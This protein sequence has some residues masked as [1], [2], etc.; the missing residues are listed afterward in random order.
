MLDPCAKG[1]T[2]GRRDQSEYP[3]SDTGNASRSGQMTDCG[4]WY[5]PEEGDYLRS[6]WDSPA[7]PTESTSSSNMY[8]SDPTSDEANKE[9][10]AC[11]GRRDS[12]D[13]PPI[14]WAS[15]GV[16]NVRN[17][18]TARV[19]PMVGRP[20][21]PPLRENRPVVMVNMVTARLTMPGG[22]SYEETSRMVPSGG[23]NQAT[24]TIVVSDSEPDS[25]YE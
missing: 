6:A 16:P 21:D 20:V 9:A 3:V 15:V 18:P 17:I 1:G 7:S 23:T 12:M 22:T 24:Q 11:G 19:H 14:D 13:D 4:E 25:D 2:P 8:F 10:G 5:L